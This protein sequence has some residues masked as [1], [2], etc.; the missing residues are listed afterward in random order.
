MFLSVKYRRLLYI[1]CI[2]LIIVLLLFLSC[3]KKYTYNNC[4]EAQNEK[5]CSKEFF[6]NGKF[7]CKWIEKSEYTNTKDSGCAKVTN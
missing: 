2:C 4:S 5:E 3:G 6:E 1:K 7:K